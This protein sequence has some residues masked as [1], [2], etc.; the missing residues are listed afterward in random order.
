MELPRPEDLIPHRPPFLFL[1]VLTAVEPGLR[2]EGEWYLRGDEPF[3]SGHFPQQPVVPGVLML[4]AIAQMGAAA[5]RAAPENAAKLIL[6]G[7]A[8]RVKFRRQVVPGD[9]LIVQAELGQRSSR[10]GKGSGRCI[11]NGKVACEAELL[12]VVADFPAP[13]P[14]SMSEEEPEKP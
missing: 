11:L 6:F 10:A 14:T 2:A 3:F 13:A 9:T 8:D 4:E 7:G 1:S 12:F 5:L